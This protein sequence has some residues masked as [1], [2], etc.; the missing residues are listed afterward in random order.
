MLLYSAHLRH[1]YLIKYA[2]ISDPEKWT[3]NVVQ[4]KK[5]K[6]TW[7]VFLK[8]TDIFSSMTSQ[9]TFS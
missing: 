3:T 4:R 1:D 9:N 6:N 5:K 7:N 8:N 2:Y